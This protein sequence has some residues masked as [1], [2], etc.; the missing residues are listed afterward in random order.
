M[1]TMIIFVLSVLKAENL[2]IFSVLMTISDANPV[3][4]WLIDCQTYNEQEPFGIHRRCFCSP[5]ECDDEI[6]TQFIDD[7]ITEYDL[8]VVDEDDIEIYSEPFTISGTTYTSSVILNTLSPEICNQKIQFKIIET[9]SPETV[10]AR[11]DCLDL[12]SSHEGSILIRYSNPRNYAGLVY[13]NTSPDESFYL[14]VP[15]MFYHEREV[16]EEEQI[17]LTD[18]IVQQNNMTK[19][20]RL[21]STDSLPDYFHK[22]LQLVL[23]HQTID[24]LDRYWVKE[25]PYDL[26]ESDRRNPL[27]KAK[28]WLTDKDSIQRNVL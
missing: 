12:A 27:Q 14:R 17:V 4:F 23:K 7:G 22:K 5:W 28:L 18:Q 24:I 10:I 11:S 16:T 9:G 13:G 8:V 26:Q 2:I 6:I 20:Q 3:Q 21:L 25:E 15:A 1:L 19:T